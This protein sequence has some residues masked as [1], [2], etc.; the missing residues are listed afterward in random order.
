M[1][2]QVYH[3]GKHLSEEELLPLERACVVCGFVGGR[4]PVLVLQRAPR[5]DLLHCRCGCRSASRMPKPEVLTEYYSG[6]YSHGNHTGYTFDD[7]AR[8][9][10]HLLRQLR[11][12][13]VPNARI[14]DFGGGIDAALSRSLAAQLIAHGAERV[15]IALVDYNADCKRDWGQITVECCP[16]LAEGGDQFDVVIASGIVEHIPYPHDTL[17]QLL[18]SLR[19]GGRAYFRTP[20]MSSTVRMAERLGIRLDFTYPAHVHDLGQVFWENVLQS[21]GAH[22]EHHLLVSRPSIVETT[23]RLHPL[24]TVVSHLFK[25]PWYFL[26]GAYTLVGGWEAVIAR[27]ESKA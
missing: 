5:V 9:G 24:P 6:Y 10:P 18:H 13:S 23:F 1:I 14:L 21:L 22:R 8:F 26:R 4:R 17:L 16:S 3:Q 15:E 20:S 12:G 25:L 19:A 2:K 7:S 11:L 27:N